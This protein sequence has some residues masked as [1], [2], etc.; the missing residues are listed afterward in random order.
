VGTSRFFAEGPVPERGPLPLSAGDVHHL[1]D[2]LRLGSGDVIELVSGGVAWT[3]R[4]ETVADEACGVRE[5]AVPEPAPLPRV[6]LAQGL[7]KGEKMDTVMRQATE[8]GVARIVPFVSQRS[9]VRL[10][11]TKA[12]ARTERWRRI[13]EGAA[14]QAHRLDVPEI[15]EPIALADLP[16]ALEGTRMLLAWEEAGDAVGIAATLAGPG[17]RDAVSV[18]VGPEGGLSAAEVQTLE[19]AGAVR[20]SLG[21]TVLRTETA[22][23]IATALAIHA[24]GG[25]G[26]SRE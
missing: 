12:T 9:V 23:V 16:G 2:V 4:L 11:R 1:R 25:L 10:D 7:A 17:A 8:L 14:K 3:V 18:I 24:L 21:P 20:V 26:A 5:D 15:A 19:E 13:A 6:T 22:G